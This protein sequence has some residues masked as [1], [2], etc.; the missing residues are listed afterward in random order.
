VFVFVAKFEEFVF[1]FP[2]GWQAALSTMIASGTT[3]SKSRNPEFRIVNSS[4]LT[5][6][7]PANAFK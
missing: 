4:L 2:A 7:F 6:A 5:V 3:I 1:D